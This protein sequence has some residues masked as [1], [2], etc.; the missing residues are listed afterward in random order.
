[1]VSPLVSL[2][3]KSLAFVRLLVPFMLGI[4][5]SYW[6]ILS[7]TSLVVLLAMLAVVLLLLQTIGKRPPRLFVYFLL[8]FLLGAWHGLAQLRPSVLGQVEGRTSWISLIEGMPIEKKNT[9]QLQVRI[10]GYYQ[11]DSLHFFR[12]PP[13]LLAHYRKN[14]SMEKEA[15]CQWQ[16]ADTLIIWGKPQVLTLPKNPKAFNYGSYLKRQ[17]ISAQLWFGPDSFQHKIGT[18]NWPFTAFRAAQQQQL[19][20]KL[21]RYLKEPKHAAIA[22][23]FSIGYRADLDPA[24]LQTF[25]STGTIHILSVSGMHVALLCLFINFL[26]KPLDLLPAGQRYRYVLSMALVWLFAWLCGLAAPVL[27][28][29][30]M[31]SFWLLGRWLCKDQQGLNILA[32]SA[33]LLLLFDPLLLFDIGFQLSYLAVVGIMLGYPLA[34]QL[35]FPKAYI[36]QQIVAIV[37][38]SISA[39]LSTC[40]LLLYYFQQFPT[41]FLLGNLWMNLPASMILVVALVLMGSPFEGL[42]T[43]LGLILDKSI[44]YSLQG[45][46]WL[47]TL[48][49]A[50]LQGI[51]VN[52]G[53]LL[54]G[55][56][57]LFLFLMA[58]RFRSAMLWNGSM[59]LTVGLLLWM[60]VGH[61]EKKQTVAFK[62]YQVGKELAVSW[63]DQGRVQLF[64]SYD[65]LQHANLR[66]STWPDLGQYAQ[67]RDIQ[68]TQV[69]TERNVILQLGSA[70]RMLIC[71]ERCSY[72]QPVDWVL[73]RHNASWEDRDFPKACILLDGSNSNFYIQQSIQKLTRL[74]RS[75][76]LLK[77]NFAYVWKR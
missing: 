4:A 72:S 37:Y 48:P 17:G 63:I 70:K 20:Q 29:S 54:L 26:L 41:Y 3:F 18:A 39:Q 50:N 71:N 25:I 57:L 15:P 2:S 61:L 36:L 5:L 55:Y 1:M 33:F 68:F 45:L 44:A 40:L 49:M 62:V 76:Y 64:S 47:E 10:L 16:V 75:Y 77:D 24:S 34:K 53:Q 35:Y 14:K 38:I 21:Q 51:Y 32:C 27:R 7:D 23:A 46:Q 31:Y 67:V 28:A 56:C 52:A 22:A 19:F 65:S 6:G 8:F 9:W 60:Q 66:F 42:N 12:R 11:N 30:L 59:L 69:P 74:N 58:I 43:W 73:L 13:K